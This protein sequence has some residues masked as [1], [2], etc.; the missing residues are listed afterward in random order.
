MLFSLKHFSVQVL[1][2]VGLLVSS[3]ILACAPDKE[4]GE[5]ISD[6][7]LRI[8]Y[9]K[10]IDKHTASTPT[11]NRVHQHAQMSSSSESKSDD[12]DKNCKCCEFGSCASCVGCSGS[13]GTATLSASSCNES[14]NTPLGRFVQKQS[15]YASLPPV[16]LEH[17]PK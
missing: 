13:C 10:D 4:F 2:L 7:I 9:E 14:A 16:P 1:V 8:S 12:I 5:I 6:T 17:P 11:K 3:N 15:I